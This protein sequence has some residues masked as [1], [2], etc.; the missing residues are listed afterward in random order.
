[1]C[2]IEQNKHANMVEFCNVL[3]SSVSGIVTFCRYIVNSTLSAHVLCSFC[4]YWNAYNA[5]LFRSLL[6]NVW[7][8]DFFS[9]SWIKCPKLKRQGRGYIH[10]PKYTYK[11][12][13]RYIFIGN[14]LSDSK[15]NSIFPTS[16]W[17]YFN[18][19]LKYHLHY[20]LQWF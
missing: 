1:M 14:L 12:F 5:Y 8:A 17:N 2:K 10:S 7:K 6:Q 9:Y 16:I 15:E 11:T 20:L 4:T 13:S 18:V 3:F 19:N